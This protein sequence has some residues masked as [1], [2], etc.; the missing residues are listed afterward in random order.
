MRYRQATGWTDR[1]SEINKWTFIGRAIRCKLYVCRLSNL[2][3]VTMGLGQASFLEMVD[4][5]NNT[6]LTKKSKSLS[7][8]SSSSRINQ[9]L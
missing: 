1:Q 9:N 5:D 3:E 7:L 4:S 6:F 8:I 2:A